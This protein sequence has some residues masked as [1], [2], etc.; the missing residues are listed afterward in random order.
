MKNS[1]IK[2]QE[3]NNLKNDL[4]EMIEKAEKILGY[5]SDNTNQL[6]KDLLSLR[7]KKSSMLA[8]DII[9]TQEEVIHMEEDYYKE[10]AEIVDDPFFTLYD[11]DSELN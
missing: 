3:I 8:N 2:E 9:D 10:E 7:T 5:V 6:V 1:E 11:E 4:D